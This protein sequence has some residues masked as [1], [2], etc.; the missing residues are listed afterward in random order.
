MD[1]YEKN[2]EEPVREL[3]VLLRDNGFNTYSSCGHDMTVSMEWYDVE[4]QQRLVDLLLENGYTKFVVETSWIFG[5]CLSS[6][7]MQLRIS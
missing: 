1:W 3:V 7:D 2:I 5:E 6:R 4:D